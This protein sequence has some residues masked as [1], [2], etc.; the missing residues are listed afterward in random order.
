MKS[1]KEDT[2]KGKKR[3]GALAAALVGGLLV[4]AQAEAKSFAEGSACSTQDKGDRLDGVVHVTFEQTVDGEQPLCL[5]PADVEA[6]IRLSASKN[7]P[8]TFFTVV[9]VATDVCNPCAVIDALLA[10]ETLKQQILAEL[11][12]GDST[13]TVGIRSV[14]APSNHTEEFVDGAVTKLRYR[15]LANVVV[16][17]K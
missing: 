10:D 8:V 16:T 3:T 15:T 7:G 6:T 13:R 1:F 11:A 9:H 2:M 17:V 5:Q 4:A 12:G 14:T